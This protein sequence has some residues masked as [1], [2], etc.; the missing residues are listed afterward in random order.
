MPKTAV[1]SY[2]FRDLFDPLPSPSRARVWAFA[3][4]RPT[5]R[6]RAM[7]RL[8]VGVGARGPRQ[9]GWA[10]IPVRTTAW[11]SGGLDVLTSS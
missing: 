7:Q 10:R 5:G 9:C 8:A 11:A 3:A 2:A 6:G 1:L 4:G